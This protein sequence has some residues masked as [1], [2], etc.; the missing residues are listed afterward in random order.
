MQLNTSSS[1]Y[2]ALLLWSLK[3]LYSQ[4][5]QWTAVDTVLKCT[6]KS[7][8]FWLNCWFEKTEEQTVIIWSPGKKSR[9]ARCGRLFIGSAAAPPCGLIWPC[10][11]LRNML[12][13]PCVIIITYI[14]VLYIVTEF[15]DYFQNI[16]FKILRTVIIFKMILNNRSCVFFFCKLP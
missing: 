16:C 12:C 7:M 4:I 10:S 6:F 9:L 13:S 3:Q 11:M 15:K 5:W 14:Q 8:V 1:R 2:F